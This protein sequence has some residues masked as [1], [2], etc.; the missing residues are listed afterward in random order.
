MPT[1]RFLVSSLTLALVVATGSLAAH[2]GPVE[3]ASAQ[4][5]APTP[6]EQA[7]AFADQVDDA[8][9]SV[10]G[11][12]QE[13]TVAVWN[14]QRPRG[15]RAGSP[16]ERQSGGSGVWVRWK[17]RGLF[18]IT[19]EHVVRD[20]DA[21]EVVSFG[22]EVLEAQLRGHV[23]QYD[24]AV[25]EVPK[26]K[27]V[28]PARFGKS[29]ALADGQWVVATG[30][31]FFL[32]ADGRPVA[33]LGIISGLDRTVVSEFTYANAI[34]HDAE[35]NRGNSG[36]PL[37]NLQG[38]L[39]GINGMIS[40]RGDSSSILP[41]NTGASFAIPI[42]LILAYFDDL[43]G[44]KGRTAAAAGWLGLDVEDARDAS[45]TPIGA[46]VKDVRPD[47]PARRKPTEKSIG[48][49]RGDVVT[50]L[51][52]GGGVAPKTLDVRCAGDFVNALAGFRAGEKVKVGFDRQGKR[53]Y[54]NGE[55]ATPPSRGK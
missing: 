15:A 51:V 30:N 49:E 5:P 50:K 39:I 38:E 4:K 8:L 52:L 23:P 34:Q 41:S 16:T 22:G 32:G 54:W 13:S 26:A 14:R 45:G 33:T 35:V 19:N 17:D 20:A 53:F 47:S 7:L 42:H 1:R 10:V 37:W 31:P 12:V 9:A 6:E 48:L 36:G 46:R 11:T 21:L 27:R 28:T 29:E 24:I 2:A 3:P 44:E 25:L 55:L 40:S 43:L 18:V